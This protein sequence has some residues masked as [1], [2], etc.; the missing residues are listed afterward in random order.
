MLRA[1]L[2]L[3]TK[4]VHVEYMAIQ[5]DFYRRKLARSGPRSSTGI[6]GRVRARRVP[7]SHPRPGPLVGHARRWWAMLAVHHASP[8]ETRTSRQPARPR[9]QKGS[10]LQVR[11]TTGL[12]LYS[13][14]GARSPQPEVAR[15]SG[16]TV[17]GGTVSGGTVS[18][19]TVSGLATCERRAWPPLDSTYVCGFR[20]LCLGM[21][22]GSLLRQA[23][24]AL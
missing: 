19:G 13:L 6:R 9:N 5:N 10:R 21:R 18:G 12:Q 14:A 24:S 8:R 4:V 15:C 22:P 17:S 3:C 23:T 20:T 16:G 7:C 1:A 11:Q 2:N